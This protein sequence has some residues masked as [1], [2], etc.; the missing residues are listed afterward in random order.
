MDIKNNYTC[1]HGPSGPD[2]LIRISADD[3][4]AGIER[5][6]QVG[7]MD[8]ARIEHFSGVTNITPLNRDGIRRALQ[9]YETWSPH[10]NFPIGYADMLREGD[11]MLRNLSPPKLRVVVESYTGGGR[12]IG[13]SCD[14]NP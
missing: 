13:M 1:L 5:S 7:L 2:G 6:L 11:E 8:H 4:N 10:C 12:V 14:S 9:G 3:L